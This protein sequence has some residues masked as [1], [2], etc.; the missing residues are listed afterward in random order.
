[1]KGK[2]DPEEMAKAR[3]LLRSARKA[4]PRFT[5]PEERWVKWIVQLLRTLP[6]ERVE[7]KLLASLARHTTHHLLQ[8]K[9]QERRETA[10][11]VLAALKARG[12]GEQR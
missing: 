4:Y 7:R 2:I 11:R 12:E 10:Q 6:E 1:M 8:K 5:L 3:K 9:S